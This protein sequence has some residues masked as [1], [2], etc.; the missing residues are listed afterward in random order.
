MPTDVVNAVLASWPRPVTASTPAFVVLTGGEPLLQLDTELLAAFEVATIEA[1]VETNGTQEIPVGK[2]WVTVSP[3]A[4]APLRVIKGHELK[5]VYPQETMEPERFQG[6]DFQ[7][8]FLQPLDGPRRL[9]NTVL[10]LH[11][12]LAHPRWRLS[13][14]THK[15][16]GIP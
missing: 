10:A 15:F 9:E 2:L 13:L 14:Q 7:H 3:K 12:C 8:F 16:L 5:L 11:Y 1:S 6:L 4:N